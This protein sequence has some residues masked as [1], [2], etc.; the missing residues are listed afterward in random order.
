[1]KKP[2][3]LASLRRDEPRAVMTV[4]TLT[5][6]EFRRELGSRAPTPGGGSA[7]CVCGSVGLGLVVMA[8]EISRPAQGDPSAELAELLERAAT[9]ELE[10]QRHA[11]RDVE[12]FSAYMRALKLPRSSSAEQAA[13]ALAVSVAAQGAADAPLA[14]GR[15]L[16][17]ALQLAARA[18][19]SVKPSLKSDVLGGAD[20]LLGAV[21]ALLRN[22][23]VNLPS[24]GDAKVSGRLLN[25][26][27]RLQH[28]A[29][30]A[31]ARVTQAFEP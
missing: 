16:L 21:S 17:A 10:I 20:L 5:L 18:G 8:L 26:R 27:R 25:E 28:E 3:L 30:V 13:R 7:A 24:V 11:D 2:S 29:L 12:A 14:A 9:L 22:V 1:L 23:D 31:H 15:D 19:G 4:W 6:A